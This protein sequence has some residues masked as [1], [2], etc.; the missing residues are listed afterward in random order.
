MMVDPFVLFRRSTAVCFA[1]HTRL[2]WLFCNREPDHK[3]KHAAIA[4]NP[5]QWLGNRSPGQWVT[6]WGGEVD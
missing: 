3:G 2:A 5:G 6:T 1:F 4:T